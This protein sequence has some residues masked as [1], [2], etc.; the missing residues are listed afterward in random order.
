MFER[1]MNIRQE[2]KKKGREITRMR[3]HNNKDEIAKQRKKGIDDFK[4]RTGKMTE[5]IEI[6]QTV[7]EAW[8]DRNNDDH[9]VMKR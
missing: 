8:D 6:E 4:D 7:L 1:S 3:Y 5:Q 2:K 9:G